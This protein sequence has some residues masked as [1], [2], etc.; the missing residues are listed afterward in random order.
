[1]AVSGSLTASMGVAALAAALLVA[2]PDADAQHVCKSLD[3]RGNV[4]Y[5]DCPPPS[6]YNADAPALRP[7]PPDEERSPAP[8]TAREPRASTK[9]SPDTTVGRSVASRVV[10]SQTYPIAGVPLLIVG[11]VVALV[12][13][14]SFLV[15]AFR[16]GFW[17]GLGCLFL[18]PVGFLFLLLHWNV[19]KR[20]FL[21]S[22]AG[23][24]AALVGYA[25]LGAPG[26]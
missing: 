23:L 20:P 22:L 12:S 16:K 6:T 2:S 10:L 8:H 15:A 5:R 1:V 18:W 25:L 3:A 11:M 19:A 17:W 24:A 13:S 26:P 4:I 14:I 9:P 7:P 21:V